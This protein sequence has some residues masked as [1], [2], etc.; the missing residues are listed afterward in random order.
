MSSGYVPGVCVYLLVLVYACIGL[1][2]YV[3][4]WVDCDPSLPLGGAS[5]GGGGAGQGVQREVLRVLGQAGH[6]SGEGVPDSGDGR[7]GPADGGRR[8]PRPPW[9]S[10]RAQ[11]SGPQ[12]RTGCEE[13]RVLLRLEQSMLRMHGGYE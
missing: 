8:S 1:S 6:W 2:A 12:G 11:D 10:P 3:C 4:V 13:G 9:G 5:G 7:Q